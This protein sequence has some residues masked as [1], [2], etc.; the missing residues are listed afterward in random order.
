MFTAAGNVEPLPGVQ[1]EQAEHARG[2]VVAAANYLAALWEAT[3]RSAR[4]GY[5]ADHRLRQ[6]QG[7]ADIAQSHVLEHILGYLA[8]GIQEPA[9]RPAV[10]RRCAR[11]QEVDVK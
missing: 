11:Q 3:R 6:E 5:P 1:R 7:R 2:E 9:K 4:G 10:A 8:R